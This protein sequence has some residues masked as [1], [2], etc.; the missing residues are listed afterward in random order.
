MSDFAG[1][2]SEGGSDIVLLGFGFWG[3]GLEG[4]G[5]RVAPKMEVIAIKGVLGKT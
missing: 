5:G 1:S 4:G 3:M 2:A